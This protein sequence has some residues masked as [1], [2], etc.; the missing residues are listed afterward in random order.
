MVEISTEAIWS[1]TLLV[2]KFFIT[3]PISFVII[4]PFRF[5]ISLGFLEDELAIGIYMF[6]LACPVFWFVLVASQNPLYFCF[7]SCNFSFISDLICI[8]S[9]FLVSLANTYI[10]SYVIHYTHIYKVYLIKEPVLSFIEL[11]IVF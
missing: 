7:I 10:Y 3:D 1:W 5:L 4:L 11:S 2:G 6:L 9:L 8:L